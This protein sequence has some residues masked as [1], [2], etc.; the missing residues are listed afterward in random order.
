MK[1]E[2]VGVTFVDI[3]GESVADDFI[4]AVGV[5]S[6]E[7]G[8]DELESSGITGEGKGPWKRKEE[9]WPETMMKSC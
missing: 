4:Q 9:K 3:I 1:R 7:E 6:G 8:A 2:A 5:V